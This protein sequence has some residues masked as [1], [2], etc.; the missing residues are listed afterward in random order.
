[1][2]HLASENSLYVSD[3]YFATDLEKGIASVRAKFREANEIDEK[4]SV[5]FFA[6]GNE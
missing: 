5:I 1:M 6:P 2:A 4:S 3:R